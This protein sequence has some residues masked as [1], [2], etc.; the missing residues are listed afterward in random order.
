MSRRGAVSGTVKLDAVVDEHGYVK[1]VKVVSGDAVLGQA[2]RN[3][4]LK[5]IYRPSTLNGKPIATNVQIQIVFGD[6]K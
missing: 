2:A 1:D 5:W 6:R 4:V 3:A